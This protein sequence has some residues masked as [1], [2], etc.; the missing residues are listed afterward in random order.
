MELVFGDRDSG[1]IYS[2]GRGINQQLPRIG[3]RRDAAGIWSTD[4]AVEPTLVDFAALAHQPYMYRITRDDGSVAYRTDL[5]S[6]CQIGSG[7]VDPE[8]SEHGSSWDG[9]R[10]D[11]DG[12]K[13]CSVVVDPESVCRSF[14]QLDTQGQPVWPET[15]RVAETDFWQ[16]EFD[17]DRP[18][19]TRLQDLV[20]YELHV[21]GL[22]FGRH[23]RGL[24]ENAIELLDYLV[25]LEVNCVE[26]MP[27]SEFEGWSGCG[28]GTSHYLAV[29][30]AAGGRDQFKHF[31]RECHRRGIAVLLDVVY[32]HYTHD[33]ERAQWAYDSTAPE[34]NIYYW[35]E[36]R[37]SDYPIP[38]GG[39]IDNM[40]TGYA[41]RYWEETV[42]KLFISSAVQLVAEFHLDGFRVDQTTS[43][44][45]NY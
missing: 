2:D 45:V 27:A 21:D 36:G 22:G 9:T 44:S 17:P 38:D 12:A 43:L 24:L 42:R 37:P 41:P 13:S 5:Y 10:F 35:Y 33:G 19:P 20:I 40:S 18:L 6:R 23:A 28:Y 3:M 1:Y 31:V 4:G 34:R 26:L 11:A 39:Y 29:E 32:N 25:E 16:H 30:Y 15:D 8:D 7:R 14:R